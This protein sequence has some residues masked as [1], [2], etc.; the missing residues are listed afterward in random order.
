MRR[1]AANREIPFVKKSGRLIFDIRD[2]DEWMERDRIRSA[3]EVI[4]GA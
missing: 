4:A 2:L 3:E 1:F